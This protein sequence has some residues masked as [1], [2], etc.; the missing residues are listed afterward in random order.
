MKTALEVSEKKTTNF[1]QPVRVY[2]EQEALN[3]PLGRQIYERVQ[4]E[5]TEIK[6]IGS[7]NRVTGIPG[8]TPQMSYR[9]A[10]RTLVVGVRRSKNFES[11]K[12]SAHYQ[13]P[14]V[15]SCPG[16]CEYCYLNT[17]LGKKPY[18]RVYVNI[19]EI[20]TRARE[21]IN[22]R[23]PEIT[24][25]EGAATSDP[26][27]VEYLSGALGRAI[28]FFGQQEYGRF[29]FVTKFTEVEG[30]LSL[31]HN[32]HTRF[33]FSINSDQVIS[34]YE[35]RTP[36]LK[37]RIQA[38]GKVFKAGYPLGFI[39]APIFVY[40][41]WQQDYRKLFEELYCQ[42]G[43][44]QDLTFEFITH[45]FTRRAKA[46]ILSLFPQSDLPMEEQERQF[47]FG[48]FGYGKFIYPKETLQEIE[49]FMKSMVKEF[50]PQ[51]KTEYF[52]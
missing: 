41:G 4:K 15:T 22:Q 28:E 14:L 12:P 36:P 47:K 45:R 6:M 21:Y 38:A 9:E 1:F 52:V 3:Y 43:K 37:E 40:D 23:K 2:F 50:F 31:Q 35:R 16:M 11:C 39:V 27:P 7:H 49:N 42:L 32:G 10:K 5:G 17:T 48:Q 46:N 29:R 33:R 44:V 8:D 34:R 18:V 24:I 19:E 13:L 26:V 20:L 51:A 25:F 30:L